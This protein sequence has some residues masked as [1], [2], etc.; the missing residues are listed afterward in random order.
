MSK[1]TPL[2]IVVIGAHVDDH[3]YGMGGT[4]LKA[5]RK[6]HRVTII[7]AVSSYCAWPVV[8]GREAEIKPHVQRISELTNTNVV[9]LGHD[10]MRLA[11]GPE[12]TQQLAVEIA[13]AEPDLVFCPWEEDSN[14]DHA[15]LGT[16][17]RVAAVHGACFLPSTHG[18]KPPRQILQYGLDIGAKNFRSD[19]FVDTG[20]VLFDM[21]QV[22][23][24]FD[25]IYSKHSAWPNALKRMTVI[26]HHNKDRTLTLNSQ[27]EFILARSL[28]RGIQCGA[29]FADAFA[30]CKSA[31]SDVNLLALI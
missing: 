1:T 16:A 30:S 27:S 31:A 23:N 2:S 25:E 12:L 5:A 3:W 10:Y 14:Q 28:V 21:L 9:T 19:I 26:D 29:R 22:N 20:E 13:R 15:V 24:V 11:N 7:Q 18:Y 17:A 8:A 6:G 4:I